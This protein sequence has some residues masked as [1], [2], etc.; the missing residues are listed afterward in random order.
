[1]NKIHLTKDAL[2]GRTLTINGNPIGKIVLGR[3]VAIGKGKSYER[4]YNLVD[5]ND[6][7]NY[8]LT[9]ISFI[10]FQSNYKTYDWDK[11]LLENSISKIAKEKFINNHVEKLKELLA[12]CANSSLATDAYYSYLDN[13]NLSECDE[14]IIYNKL[15][16]N[17]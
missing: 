7:H 11:I 17:E 1:M 10:N 8:I 3:E 14:D 13:E 9:D 4:Y 15:Y 6:K 5:I 16:D 2:E 12:T